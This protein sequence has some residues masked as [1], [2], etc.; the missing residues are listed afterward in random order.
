MSSSKRRNVIVNTPSIKQASSSHP[1]P[2]QYQDQY[3][4][5]VELVLY[6]LDVIQCICF[7][8][9]HDIFSYRHDFAFEIDIKVIQVSSL[10][11]KHIDQRAFKR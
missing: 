5:K 10:R 7:F 4:S 6:D 9:I 2:Q 11:I 1:Q 3:P 8:D